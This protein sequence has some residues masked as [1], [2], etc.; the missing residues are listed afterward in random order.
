MPSHHDMCI[1]CP[2]LACLHLKDALMTSK[3]LAKRF[4]I[5][6]HCILWPCDFNKA[7]FSLQITVQCFYRAVRY[8][9]RMF[10]QVR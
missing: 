6:R 5:T 2:S 10:V 7:R 4:L 3:R 1:T 9:H 8:Q